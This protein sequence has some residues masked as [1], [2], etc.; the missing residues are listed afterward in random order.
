MTEQ[1]IIQIKKS[2]RIF[3][4]IDP[5]LV[6]GVFYDKLFKEY[7]SLR[8]MFKGPIEQQSQKL[9]D[10]LSAIVMHLDHLDDLKEDIRSLAVRHVAY[11]VKVEHYNAVGSALLWTL[12]QGLGKDWN[13]ETEEAWSSCYGMLAA[14]MIQAAAQKV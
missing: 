5:Q 8:K 2:W 1:Q 13:N 14:T 9:I 10:M 7:P 6:G 12:Q 4:Q 3:R 11:G